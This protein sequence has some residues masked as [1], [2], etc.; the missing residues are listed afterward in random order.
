MRHRWLVVGLAPA[1]AMGTLAVALVDHSALASRLAPADTTTTAPG[2]IVVT[3]GAT[4]S[5]QE[6]DDGIEPGNTYAQVVGGV[7]PRFLKSNGH[8]WSLVQG[9]DCR[10]KVVKSLRIAHFFW[11]RAERCH[12]GSVLRDHHP[13]DIFGSAVLGADFRLDAID[14]ILIG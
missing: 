14:F 13:S 11:T 8:R 5:E 3:G 4:T 6:G 10:L 9:E 12:R 1:L 2:S 7:G